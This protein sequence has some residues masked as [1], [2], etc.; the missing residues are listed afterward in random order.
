MH[1][2]KQ[3][4]TVQ[5]TFTGWLFNTIIRRAFFLKLPKNEQAILI[6]WELQLTW[7][8]NR[9]GPMGTA[10]GIVRLFLDAGIVRSH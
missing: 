2:L 7:A 5:I 4:L 1:F 10:F 8:K 9:K 3:S 6:E